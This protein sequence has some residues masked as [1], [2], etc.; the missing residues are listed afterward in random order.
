MKAQRVVHVHAKPINRARFFRAPVVMSVSKAKIEK[1]SRQKHYLRYSAEKVKFPILILWG[2]S[3]LLITLSEAWKRQCMSN[4]YRDINKYIYV[5]ER[6][7]IKILIDIYLLFCSTI[8]FFKA[9]DIRT[10]MFRIIRGKIQVYKILLI[11]WQLPFVKNGWL[12][13]SF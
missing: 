9:R 2:K 6:W 3:C 7:F 10:L 1:C 4:E 12:L 5:G 8:F 13:I 11:E